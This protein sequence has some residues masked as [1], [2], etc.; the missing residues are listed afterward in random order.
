MRTSIRLLAPGPA[1]GGGWLPAA[2]GAPAESGTLCLPAGAQ[3][4]L[5]KGQKQPG[6]RGGGASAGRGGEEG[7]IGSL[8]RGGRSM[9]G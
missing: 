3:E 5:V 7:Q 9:M 8:P 6:A 4:L 2:G 1:P